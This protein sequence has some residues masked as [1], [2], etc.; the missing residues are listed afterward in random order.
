MT[1]TV[2]DPVLVLTSE[3]Q[4]AR[5]GSSAFWR[6]RPE[7]WYDRVVLVVLGLFATVLGAWNITGA[8]AYQDDEGTYTA[9]AFSVL[10]G[11]LAPYT[12]WYDH[13]PLGWIQ[14]AMLAWL[15][16][17]LGIGGDTYIGATRYVIVPFFVATTLLVYLLA[18][19]VGVRLPLAALGAV[20]F[21]ICPLTL[22]IGRQ[23]YLDNIGMP[24]LLLAFYLALSPRSALW[25]HIAAGALFA[26]AVLS[27]E[28]LA[29]FGPALLLALLNRPSWSNRVFSVVG[30]LVTGALVLAF[31]PLMAVLSGELLA[32]PDHVSLQEALTFQFLDRSGSGS[33]WEAGSSRSELVAGWLYF[34]RFLIFAGLAA[35]LL[36]LVRRSTVWLT[37]A[38][39]TAAVPVVTG[40]GYLPS[41]Y[42]IAVVPFL[43]IAL[44]AGLDVLRRG[45]AHLLTSLPPRARNA[46]M[47]TAA[48][49]LT[50]V[51]AVTAVPQW[52]GKYRDLLALDANE[53]W[54]ATLEWVQHNVPQEDTILVP[55]SMWQDV[56]ASGWHDP[57]EVIVTE[58]AD[59]DN[60]FD[61]E[62][63]QGWRSIDWLVVGPYT[64][65]N[66][67]SLGL[68]TVGSALEASEEVQRFGGWSVHKV[69][70]WPGAAPPPE[71]SDAVARVGE[72]GADK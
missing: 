20:L 9:Q 14:T 66:I 22:A 34:D 69:T 50:V 42:V 26:V 11:D 1:A 8:S 32:G 7:A 18:R 52:S 70:D 54:A 27:K 56:N 37:V 65:S 25:H 46:G 44:A 36:C 51:L 38:I 71:G 45:L 17:S 21:V 35:A 55:Y 47:G 61:R 59:L 16:E 72:A 19:R 57:W 48:A 64:E 6:G 10:Q 53:D 31:Y 29:L 24:W 28:T 67:D 41:M 68:E 3:P 15:P 62:H 23:V 13:P 5:A 33:V 49:A 30:F 2:S 12:Y 63:P 4:P 60:Q 40:Q 58:K 39:T 43:A